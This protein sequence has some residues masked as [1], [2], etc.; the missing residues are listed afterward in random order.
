MT[1]LDELKALAIAATKGPWST[2]DNGF[3]AGVVSGYRKACGEE[4]AMFG[5]GF[6]YETMI[7]GGEPHEG[8]FTGVN[9]EYVAAAN[10]ERLLSLIEEIESLRKERDDYKEALEFYATAQ[11]INIMPVYRSTEDGLICVDNKRDQ[12]QIAREALNKW[13]DKK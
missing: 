8:R 1:P 3:Y 12:G 10:P 11:G 4:E 9:A 7:C 2:Y 13:K 5:Y 6:T